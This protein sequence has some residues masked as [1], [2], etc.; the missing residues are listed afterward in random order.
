[1]TIRRVSRRRTRT[2]TIESHVVVGANAVVLPNVT[3]SEGAVV[4]AGAS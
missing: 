1:M 4:G 3:I 2:L